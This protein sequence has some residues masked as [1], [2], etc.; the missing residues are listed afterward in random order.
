MNYKNTTPEE[1]LQKFGIDLDNPT[2]RDAVAFDLVKL[3]DGSVSNDSIYTYDEH[4]NY[5]PREYERYL[6]N[7]NWRTHLVNLDPDWS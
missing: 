7:K 6:L 1:F 4:K 2:V 3:D 5:S